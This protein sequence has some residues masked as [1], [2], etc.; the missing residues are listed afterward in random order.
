MN[1]ILTHGN[2]RHAIAI[3]SPGCCQVGGDF[4]HFAR[5]TGRQHGKTRL[6]RADLVCFTVLDINAVAKARLCFLLN[7]TFVFV[8]DEVYGNDISNT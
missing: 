8:G 2:R 4:I 7:L 1:S 5:A 3:P 6:Y